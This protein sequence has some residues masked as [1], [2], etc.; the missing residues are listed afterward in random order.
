M[1]AVPVL[2]AFTGASDKVHYCT[3][4]PQS[5]TPR[6]SGKKERGVGMHLFT[7]V[8]AREPAGA[9]WEIVG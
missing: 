4:P 8:R 1:D 9:R 7:L 2:L 6:L 3:F 5:Q